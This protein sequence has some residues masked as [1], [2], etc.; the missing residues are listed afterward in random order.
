MPLPIEMYTA[1]NAGKIQFGASEKTRHNGN[2]VPF[3]VEDWRHPQIIIQTPLVAAPFG[4]SKFIDPKNPSDVSYNIDISFRDFKSNEE[5]GDFHARMKQLDEVMLG[6][7]V[8]NSQQW[9]NLM[10]GQKLDEQTVKMFL[11]KLVKDPVRKSDDGREYAPTMRIKVPIRNG[12][13]A[14]PVFD[15]MKRE[16]DIDY[17]TRGCMLKI[18]MELNPAVWFVNKTYGVTW[19]VTQVQVTS[20]PTGLDGYAF[21]E[22]DAS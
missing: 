18:I 16:V 7:G 6:A 14:C 2:R 3:R 19:K 21:V 22:P 10:E 9:F 4:V 15:E 5:M 20:R 1:F 8:E 17:I 13:P 12:V 11:R